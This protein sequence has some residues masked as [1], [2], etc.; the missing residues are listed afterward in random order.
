MHKREDS[1]GKE[2]NSPR[3]RGGH[4]EAEK[5]KFCPGASGFNPVLSGNRTIR[6]DRKNRRDGRADLLSSRYLTNSSNVSFSGLSSND[7]AILVRRQQRVSDKKA[8]KEENP[9]FRT[10]A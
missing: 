4:S 9:G 8:V 5:G 7:S 1:H 3:S 2:K 10:S 6:Q